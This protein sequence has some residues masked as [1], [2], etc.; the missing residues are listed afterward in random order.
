MNSQIMPNAKNDWPTSFWGLLSN[1]SHDVIMENFKLLLQMVD[2][3]I[4][5]KFQRFEMFNNDFYFIVNYIN[6][7][8]R[9][10]F[11]IQNY[12]NY[13][14]H[15]ILRGSRQ[16]FNAFIKDSLIVWNYLRL[17]SMVLSKLPVRRYPGNSQKS[18]FRFSAAAALVWRSGMI[19]SSSFKSCSD[20]SLAVLE[21]TSRW[22]ASLPSLSK[23][24]SSFLKLLIAFQQTDKSFGVKRE[25][26]W[27]VLLRGSRRWRTS[28]LIASKIT[29]FVSHVILVTFKFWFNFLYLSIVWTKD[30]IVT[31]PNRNQK[32]VDMRI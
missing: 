9:V 2:T 14:K 10:W 27:S 8:K 5:S 1:V 4:I 20:I 21:V 28:S 18:L 31:K 19:S 30:L 25:T 11:R 32:I 6:T 13:F 16:D 17:I 3:A 15:F 7:Q 22:I 24:N 26:S 23:T 12:A 29:F